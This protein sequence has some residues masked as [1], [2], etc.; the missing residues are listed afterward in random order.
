VGEAW[1]QFEN[2]D[3]EEHQTLE[4][5]IRGLMKTEQNEETLRMS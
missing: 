2:A 1:G 5:V 3:K 4:A